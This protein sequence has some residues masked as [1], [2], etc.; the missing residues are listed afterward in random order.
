MIQEKKL[1]TST[2]KHIESNLKKLPKPIILL[3]DFFAKLDKK[4]IIKTLLKH[5]N[6]NQTI[7][8]TT[9]TTNIDKEIEEI[10][11]QNQTKEIKIIK[12]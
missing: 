9:D 6:K 4:N 12:L 1:F 7:I 11:R 8:T 3:D 2:L 10:Q 5:T